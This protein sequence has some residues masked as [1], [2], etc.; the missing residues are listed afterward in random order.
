MH[1]AEGW[2]KSTFQIGKLILHLDRKVQPVL[3]PVLSIMLAG[4]ILWLRARRVLFGAKLKKNAMQTALM[5]W[6]AQTC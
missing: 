2:K 3:Q 4:S 5:R 6:V 1:L